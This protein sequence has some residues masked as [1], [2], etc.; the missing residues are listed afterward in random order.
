ME[1]IVMLIADPRLFFILNHRSDAMMRKR[2][3]WDE[4][5]EWVEKFY[6][7]PFLLICWPRD[8][9]DQRP[10]MI[11]L[12]STAISFNCFKC[13][14]KVSRVS[15][16]GKAARVL[17]IMDV[18]RFGTS[19]NN[20]IVFISTKSESPTRIWKKKN[21]RAKLWFYLYLPYSGTTQRSSPKRQ[22]N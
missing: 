5:V 2:M 22:N 11:L 13:L 8:G 20:P 4:S 7:S 14:K 18:L 21:E 10:K 15:E 16:W 3:K 6:E 12:S 19:K 1:K 17:P 9:A